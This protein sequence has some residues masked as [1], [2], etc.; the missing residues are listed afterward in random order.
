[1][2]VASDFIRPENAEAFPRRLSILGST[3]SIGGSA[4]EL[5]RRHP[6]KFRVQALAAGRNVEKL[7]AQV[8]EFHPVLAVIADERQL[9]Q[10][11]RL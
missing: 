7:A 10:L 11:L 4:L 3:G 1:M 6:D 9:P 2:L 5:V 8:R